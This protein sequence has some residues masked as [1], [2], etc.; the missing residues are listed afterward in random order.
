MSEDIRSKIVDQLDDETTVIFIDGHDEAIMGLTDVDG[1]VRVVYSRAAI[2]TRLVDR[3][4]MT[5][6]EAEE[7]FEFNIAGAHFGNNDPLFVTGIEEL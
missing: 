3:D 7:Y 2:I 1:D 5:G 4:S 6:E